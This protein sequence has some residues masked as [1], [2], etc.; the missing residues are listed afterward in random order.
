MALRW[1]ATGFLEAEKSFRR[2]QGSKDLWIL[3]SA[4]GRNVTG[5]DSKHRVA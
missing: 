5:I 2:L 1:T 4:L 3:A